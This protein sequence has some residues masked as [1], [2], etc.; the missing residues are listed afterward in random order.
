M[1]IIDKQKNT[2]DKALD[3]LFSVC[4][5][6]IVAGGAPRDWY[7][8]NPAKDIDIFITTDN[9]W[10]T[11]VTGRVLS[12]LGFENVSPIVPKEDGIQNYT[13]NPNIKFVYNCKLDGESIQIIVL[14]D[15]TYRI[16]DTFAFNICKVWYKNSKIN[17]TADFEYAVSNKVIVKQ[18][19]LYSS[20]TAY[21]DKIVNKF[22][23]YKYYNSESEFL[24]SMYKASIKKEN[25]ND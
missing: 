6:A 17:T 19:E 5:S 23:E 1:L 9:R 12:R 20:T 4:P 11:R 22:P 24:K 18:G 21:K 25:S 7:L 8:G 14:Y 15:S 2:A 10:T 3:I 16:V 13:K